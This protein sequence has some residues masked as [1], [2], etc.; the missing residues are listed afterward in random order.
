MMRSRNDL[1][2]LSRDLPSFSAQNEPWLPT[3]EPTDQVRVWQVNDFAA[4]TIPESYEPRYAYPLVVWLTGRDCG[5]DDSL[6]HIAA[7]S[8]QNYL[9]LAVDECLFDFP[10][11]ERQEFDVPVEFLK[12]LIDIEDRIVTAVRSLRQLVNVHTERIFLAGAGDAA[13]VALLVA[14]HQP[15]WF[16]G[17]IA[18]GGSFPPAA[19]LLAHHEELAGRRFFLGAPGGRSAW[20]TANSVRN[21]AHQLIS[22][23][24]DVSLNASETASLVNRHALSE[25]DHW[26]ISGIL[27]DAS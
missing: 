27:A 21:T 1:S 3:V 14:M 20:Q 5:S 26:I 23:G 6:D 16:G 22:A 13:S 8:P 11:A 9:G 19:K 25:V 24:A 15:D 4:G 17:C 7:M 10:E 12:R 2:H 18:F